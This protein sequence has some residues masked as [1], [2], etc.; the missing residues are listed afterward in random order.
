MQVTPIGRVSSPRRDA[1]D[2][3]WGDIVSTITLDDDFGPDALRGLE[4]FSHL[5]IV[6]VFDRVRES[7]CTPVSVDRA[8]TRIGPRSASSPSAARR[9]RID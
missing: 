7:S 9:D 5:E 1:I 8:I 3:D 2:D 4:E 6:Y